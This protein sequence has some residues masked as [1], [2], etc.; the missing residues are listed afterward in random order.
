MHRL[1]LTRRGKPSLVANAHWLNR[2]VAHP[3]VRK[4]T[5]VSWPTPATA[6]LMASPVGDTPVRSM[7]SV[8]WP[9]AMPLA[10]PGAP[11]AEP[12][13]FRTVEYAR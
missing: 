9:N 13:W 12:K 6:R 10:W 5:S 4:A 1:N 7:T 3:E 2:Q 11:P 8:A